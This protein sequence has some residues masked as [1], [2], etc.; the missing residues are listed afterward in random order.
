M[1]G[2]EEESDKEY[3]I[4]GKMEEMVPRWFHKYLR[5]FEKKDSERMPMRKA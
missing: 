4:V 1:G 2:K 5:I 3:M